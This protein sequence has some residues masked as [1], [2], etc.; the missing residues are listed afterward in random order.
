MDYSPAGSSVLGISQARILEWV[1]I[2]FSRGSSQTKDQIQV[3]CI[4]GRY[5]TCATWEDSTF[6]LFLKNFYL[7]LHCVFVASCRLSLC[8]VC[9]LL[10]AVAFLVWSID[11]RAWGLSSSGMWNFPG[12]GIEPLSPAFSRW[13]LNH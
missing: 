4:A 7:W 3:S 8:A 11:S 13:T 12:P 9:G 5:F 6:L 1:T 10:I 2:S